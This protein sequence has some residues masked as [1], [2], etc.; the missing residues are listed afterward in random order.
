ME[1]VRIELSQR[2]RDRLKVLYEIEQ[3]HIDA[4]RCG[5]CGRR[6]R[7]I[8]LIPGFGHVS[9]YAGRLEGRGALTGRHKTARL[10]V[11]GAVRLFSDL[12]GI[13]LGQGRCANCLAVRA[14]ARRCVATIFPTVVRSG[15]HIIRDA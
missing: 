15:A 7:W 12:V 14:A 5:G 13:A 2:E 3:K 11:W 4:A 10:G 6:P 1:T 9:G 8:I